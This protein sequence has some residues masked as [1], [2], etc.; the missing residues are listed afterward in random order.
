[1][2]D[3]ATHPAASRYIEAGTG[4]FFSTAYLALAAHRCYLSR[5]NANSNRLD[6]WLLTP[7]QDD[8]ELD[9]R[10]SGV[11]STGKARSRLHATAN[12]QAAAILK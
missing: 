11:R 6:Q 1:M 8:Q 10:Q 9:S 5:G 4:E 2:P 12:P 3:C 7:L